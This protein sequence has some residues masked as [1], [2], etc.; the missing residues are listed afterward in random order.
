ME[1]DFICVIISLLP[2][3]KLCSGASITILGQTPNLTLVSVQSEILLI[4]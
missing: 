4:F 1:C 3:I 2:K